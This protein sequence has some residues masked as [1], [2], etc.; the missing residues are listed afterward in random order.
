MM[1]ELLGRVARDD[2]AALFH[3]GLEVMLDG[4]ATRLPTV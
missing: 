1:D 2:P 3:F 4:L